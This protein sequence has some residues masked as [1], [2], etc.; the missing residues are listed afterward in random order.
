MLDRDFQNTMRAA[1]NAQVPIIAVRTD[2]IDTVR[3]EIVA[4]ILSGGTQT[5]CLEWRLANGFTKFDA[6]FTKP[7]MD[8]ET[9]KV[10]NNKSVVSKRLTSKDFKGTYE[11]KLLRFEENARKGMMIHP[12]A[13]YLHGRSEDNE[14]YPEGMANWALDFILTNL[15]NSRQATSE[16][17]RQLPIFIL[18]DYNHFLEDYGY[19]TDKL[20]LVAEKLRAGGKMNIIITH[21]GRWEIPSELEQ[22]VLKVKYKLPAIEKRMQALTAMRNTTADIP[23]Q[24]RKYPKVANADEETIEDA[25]KAGGGLTLSKFDDI[26]CMGITETK[27]FS[28][29]YILQKKKEMMEEAGMMLITPEVSFDDVGGLMPLKNWATRLKRRFSKEAFEYGFSSYPTGMLLSG[30][31]GCGKSLVAKAMAREWGM[32]VIQV[33]ATDL[34]GSLVGES[35]AKVERMLEM[36]SANAPCMLYLDEGEKLLGQQDSVRDGGAHDGVLAQFLS[37]MQDNNDGVYVVMTANQSSKFPAELI[38]RFDGRWFVDVPEKDEREPIIDIHLKKFGRESSDFNM[39]ELVKQSD[40]R[41]GWDIEVAINDA[42]MSAFGSDEES[43]PFDTDDILT[44][45]KENPCSAEIKKED[46]E[47]M[48]EFLANGTMRLANSSATQTEGEVVHS[49]SFGG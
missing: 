22:Q 27:E 48:R 32:N 16:E 11:D 28:N 29:D 13:S 26:V 38:R 39:N 37:F 12:D 18:R 1:I 9:K 25:A 40:G 20:L 36:A 43:R 33:R 46:V 35:E 23:D 47:K 7:V 10:D 24:S 30:V 8:P 44:S 49:R 3:S 34:K 2:E 41:T 19:L 15:D 14:G 17:D 42:A 45:F 21:S 31:P 4:N 6:L 5:M